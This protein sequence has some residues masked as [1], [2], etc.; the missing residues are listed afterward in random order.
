MLFNSDAFVRRGLVGGEFVDGVWQPVSCGKSTSDTL[1]RE[2]FG[3]EQ[4]S[5]DDTFGVFIDV[6]VE[7]GEEDEKDIDAVDVG[8]GSGVSGE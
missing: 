6:D 5:G 7:E 4:W 2:D 8:D 3:G 1:V